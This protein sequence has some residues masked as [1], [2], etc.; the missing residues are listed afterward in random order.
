MKKFISVFLFGISIITSA[1]DC[2]DLFG[3][4]IKDVKKLNNDEF[5]FIADNFKITKVDSNFDTIWHNDYLDTTNNQLNKIQPTFDGGFIGAGGGPAG[6]L[7]KFNNLGDTI[8][9]K[10]V[11]V[12]GPGPFGGFSI[13]DIIQTSDSG[14]AFVAFYGHNNVN[15][16]IVKT[17]R[18]GDTLWARLNILSSQPSIDK[19]VR[20]ICEMNNGDLIVSGSVAVVFPT[21]GSLAFLLKLNSNGDSLWAKTYD[22]FEFNSLAIDIN[23]D[24]I[25]AGRRKNSSN[26]MESIIL[27]ADST[28]DSIWTKQVSAKLINCVKI[29]DGGYAFA[30]SKESVTSF[31]SSYLLKTN[32]NGDSLWSNIYPEDSTDRGL[33]IIYTLNNKDYLLFGQELAIQSLAPFYQIDYRIQVD[34]L[35][36][37]SVVSQEES[38]LNKIILSPNPSSGL[39]S[40]DVDQEHIGSSYQILDNLGRLIDKGIIRELFQDFDLSNRPKGVYIIQVFNDKAIKTLN[41]VI[42]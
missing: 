2:K 36:I 1:Q 4:Q 6:N 16:M 35:G 17:D 8:W 11:D 41:V 42:Q 37:C 29:V 40:I 18:N 15:S 13:R 26:A 19:R 24:F 33:N 14:Y 22:N 30:G 5:I 9:S 31:S 23:Q 20:T 34:S 38:N 25:I 32:S 27:K 10:R 12:F 21:S 28:G 7:F 3:N 39:F